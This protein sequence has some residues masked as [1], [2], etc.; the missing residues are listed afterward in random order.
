MKVTETSLPGVLRI[1][2]EAHVD[3]R[4]RFVRV[5]DHTPYAQAGI[6]VAFAQDNVSVSGP[7]V[8]RGL[9]FQ[10]RL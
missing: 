3:A 10:H 7:G 6:P 9:H 4:G 8:L 2:L 5:F 1:D